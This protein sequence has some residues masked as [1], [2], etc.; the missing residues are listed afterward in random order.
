MFHNKPNAIPFN[1]SN[2]KYVGTLMNEH[3]KPKY[4]IQQAT[5]IATITG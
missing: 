4:I 2:Q 5:A 3:V 1:A